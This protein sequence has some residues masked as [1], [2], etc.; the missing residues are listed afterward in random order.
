M[1]ASP[2]SRASWLANGAEQ[3][4]FPG[5]V[6]TFFLGVIAVALLF[7]VMVHGQDRSAP[8][9]SRP[10][11]S[12]IRAT[13]LLRIRQLGDVQISPDGRSIAYTVRRIVEAD[14][15]STAAPG[16]SNASQS[17]HPYRYHTQLYVV[18]A[19]GR[20][21]PR[22]LTRDLSGASDPAWHPSTDHLAFVRP[23]DGTPQI[24]LLSLTGGEPY[25]LTDAEHGATDPVWA[26]SGRRL[27]FASSLP[28]RAVQKRSGAAG[29]SERPGRSPQDT[30]VT[31]SRQ[32]RVVLR[33]SVTLDPVD[34]L[35]VAMSDSIRVLVDSLGAL[36]DTITVTAK[37]PDTSPAPDGSL[38]QVRTWLE[39]RSGAGNPQV[40]NR[41][42]FQGEQSLDP[43][44]SYRHYFT[45]SV[46]SDVLSADRA[47]PEPQAVTRGFR[48]FDDAVW[49]P[50]G[51][52]IIAS[53]PPTL[54]LHP[55]RVRD[56]DLYAVDVDGSGVRRLLS[57]KH[58]AL[59]DPQLTPDGTTVAFRATDRR[60][61]GYAQSEIGLFALDG[62]TK[63]QLIT[64]DFDRDVSAPI[65]SPD[66][67]YLY[68][69]APSN[70]GVPLYRFAPFARTDTTD[71]PNPPPVETSGESV[72]RDTFAI[73]ST[74]VRRVPREQLTELPRGVHSFDA[75]D[76]AVA[77]V[78]TDASNPYEL[79]A[80]TVGFASER[81]LSAHNAAWLE[82]RQLATP[83]RFTV[84]RDSLS[85]EGWAMRPP[86]L[87]ANQQAPLLLEMHGGPMAMWGPGEATMWHEFQYLAAQGYAVVYANPRGS[88]GYGQAF[89]RANYK[90]WGPGPAADVLA[91]A[92]AAV[93][94]FP[95]IDASRQVLTGGS[96]AGYLTAWMVSQTDRFDAAVAQRGVY[97]L[98]TF[99]GEGNAWRLVPEH[100]GGY[101]WEGSVPPPAGQ[102]DTPRAPMATDSTD[103]ETSS[104]EEPVAR[105]TTAVDTTMAPRSALLRNSPITYAPRIRTPLLI[106]HASE[107]LRTGVS[108]SEMLYR[109]LKVLRRPVEYVRYPH[110]GHD[111][112]RSGAPQQRL[113]RMLRIYE[114]FARYTNGAAPVQRPPSDDG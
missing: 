85:I 4:R 60:N 37:G 64:D 55:D 87:N 44:P 46:P 47:R 15:V 6:Q 5:L 67:W 9:A 59:T 26:P 10:S 2:S 89:K 71:T 11:D 82:D 86:T 100:F 28:E 29:P 38:L 62:R 52:Q 40:T 49:L 18:P 27:L 77:Y 54:S 75:T 63:P 91:A 114:F 45:V 101:P 22:P 14:E 106:M 58:H 66:G 51:S 13:D 23:V 99:F 93:S 113:D 19:S 79:Y 92:D 12:R 57:L 39:R 61:A 50:G 16:P 42:D 73:D 104:E 90:N 1:P 53:A 41:L 72:S 20:E 8:G 48:S 76:A 105:D 97:D 96:Y 31:A 69:T 34:T 21:D 35:D 98:S 30:L 65:W 33:D 25:Q 109:T 56:R 112:S 78:A 83:Q 102:S 43:E 24:F 32:T 3:V 84:T 74:M 36:R 111:L 88:G 70:G 94:R 7:P 81:R 95:W 103:A 80:N 68:V 107:D 110:A 108:Q 17:T